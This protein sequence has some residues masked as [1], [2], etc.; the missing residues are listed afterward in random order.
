[1]SRPSKLRRLV[2]VLFLCL[3]LWV[4]A[5][6]L[7][8]ETQIFTGKVVGVSDGD[9]LKVMHEGRAEKVRLAD[10]DCPEK[11]QPYGQK[12][13]QFASD[14]AFAQ[15]VT[16]IVHGLDRYGRSIG[17]VTLADGRLLNRELVKA[18]LAWW[19]RR[20]SKDTSYEALESEAKADKRGLWRDSDPTPPW[21]WRRT[22]R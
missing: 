11:A 13:K 16:V 4:H 21:E 6:A 2:G 1:M 9:T 12:A 8:A 3:V 19:Y 20:Y 18:G 14:L 7:S 17:E 22:K 5:L 10:I 15:V